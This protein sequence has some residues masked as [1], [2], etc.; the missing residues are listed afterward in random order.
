MAKMFVV[1]NCLQK[2]ALAPDYLT[3]IFNFV[4][5]LNTYSTR[6]S[7]IRKPFVYLT[8]ILPVISRTGREFVL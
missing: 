5:F 7:P 1:A 6:I 4:N 8:L 3:S 2:K